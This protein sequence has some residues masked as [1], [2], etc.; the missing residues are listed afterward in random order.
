MNTHLYKDLLNM[1]ARSNN[2]H[3]ALGG[4]AKPNRSKVVS[5]RVYGSL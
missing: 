5:L 1:H 4:Q 3:A 2:E